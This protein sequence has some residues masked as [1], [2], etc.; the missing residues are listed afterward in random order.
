MYGKSVCYHHGGRTPTGL[1]N[2]QTTHG[3]YSKYLPARMQESFEAAN[4]DTELLALRSNISMLYSRLFDLLGR[5]DTGE[6][7][8]LWNSLAGCMKALRQAQKEGNRAGDPVRQAE[9]KQ[10]VEEAIDALETTIFA[11]QSDYAAWREVLSVGE[12]IR[13]NSE[14]EQ[15]RLVAMQQMISVEQAIARDGILYDIITRHVT[16]RAALGRIAFEFKQLTQLE[17]GGTAR[18][19]GVG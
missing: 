18:A 5:V 16:D 14:S 6:A 17:P 10:T 11:G 4:S 7:G 13:K 12:Q 15:K 2:P 8:E 1:A 3:R 19:A 9:A